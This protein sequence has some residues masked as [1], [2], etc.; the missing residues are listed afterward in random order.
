MGL[1][2]LTNDNPLFRKRNVRHYWERIMDVLCA[3]IPHSC[4]GCLTDSLNPEDHRV[5]MGNSVERQVEDCLDMAIFATRDTQLRSFGE[6]V[7]FRRDLAKML[8]N[9][10]PDYDVMYYATL[11]RDGLRPLR[12]CFDA[13]GGKRTLCEVDFHL[14]VLLSHGQLC[15][16]QRRNL[17]MKLLHDEKFRN[18]LVRMLYYMLVSEEEEEEKKKTTTGHDRHGFRVVATTTK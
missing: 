17:R 8:V 16:V 11:L 9:Q 10:K 5:C 4:S 3:V 15:P 14:D 18:E 2:T 1:L 12:A 13:G 7:L 6:N